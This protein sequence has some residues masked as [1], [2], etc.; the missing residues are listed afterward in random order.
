MGLEQSDKGEVMGGE[1]SEEMG[2]RCTGLWATMRSLALISNEVGAMEA[3]LNRGGMQVDLGFNRILL[4]P[5]RR[6]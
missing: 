4:G 6:G 3:L 1:A 5:V 2:I